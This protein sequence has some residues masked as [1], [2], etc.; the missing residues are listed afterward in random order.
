MNEKW[1]RHSRSGEEYYRCIHKSGLEIMVYPKP[2]FHSTYA[3]FGTKFGSIDRTFKNKNGE[4]FTCPEGTAHFL[5]HKLFEGEK[6]SAFELYAK[7]GASA[8]AYT[9]FDKTCYLF[10]CTGNEYESLEILLDFVQS[11]YFTKETIEKEQGIIGQ[12]IKMYDDDPQWKVMF[13]FLTSMYHNHTV[14]EDIAGS[15]ESISEITPEVLYNFYNNFYNL[16]NMM[17]CVAGNI[18]VDKVLEM[19]DRLL[20]PCDEFTDGRIMPAEPDTVVKS[21]VTQE[22]SMALPLFEFGF[23]EDPS[24]STDL[25]KVVAME[26]IIEIAASD[27]S[28]LFRRLLDSGLINDSSFSC[29]VFTGRGYAAT[30][31]SGESKDPKTVS[32]E[33]KKEIIR[34]KKE[35]FDTDDFT[36]AKKSLYGKNIAYLNSADCVGS[37]LASLYFSGFEL[38]DYIDM[39][40]DIDEETVL[41]VLSETMNE[42]KCVLSVV[43]P[44]SN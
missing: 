40:A 5:E 17:L 31:F 7:T 37:A 21:E 25:S 38:F 20:K 15:V 35:G 1:V 27:C 6:G 16:N 9:S 23:K 19:A 39:I 24:L 29:E 11:P 41:K 42:D 30:V 2:Q 32:E 13:N 34:I 10:S 12:E 4:V 44:I 8:N 22:L 43:K 33:I 18:E 28:P 3:V 14:K 26:I 36:R